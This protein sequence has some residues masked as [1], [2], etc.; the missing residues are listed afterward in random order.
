MTKPLLDERNH[1]VTDKIPVVI[2]FEIARIAAIS[3][4]LFMEVSEDIGFPEKQQRPD[5]PAVH[6]PDTLETEKRR[7]AEQ[8]E[9]H[10]FGIVANMMSGYD[11]RH[12]MLREQL[13]E[14]VVSQLSRTLF[15]RELQQRRKIGGIESFMKTLDTHFGAPADDKLFIIIALPAAKSEIA[16][17]RADT[18]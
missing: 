6:R 12:P 3:N 10:G 5:N 16:V 8:I 15:D 1:P 2:G 17:S 14:P 18:A 9:Q 7:A 11:F 13:R 4:P